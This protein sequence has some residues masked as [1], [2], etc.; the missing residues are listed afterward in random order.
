M[1]KLTYSQVDNDKE[2]TCK[3][4]KKYYYMSMLLENKNLEISSL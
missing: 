4:K 1:S 3:Q 2:E